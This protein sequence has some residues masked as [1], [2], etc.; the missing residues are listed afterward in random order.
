MERQH[1]EWEFAGLENVVVYDIYKEEMRND[2]KFNFLLKGIVS[3]VRDTSVI[4][5]RK[6][7]LMMNFDLNEKYNSFFDNLYD[8][9][10]LS[11]LITHN[12][13]G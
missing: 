3:L 6:G 10:D 8:L 4:Y 11:L 12:Y 13:I 7:Y 1:L 5:F 2:N 9:V